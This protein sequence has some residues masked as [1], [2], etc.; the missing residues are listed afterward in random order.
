[1]VIVH[2]PKFIPNGNWN[3]KLSTKLRLELLNKD[4]NW[5]S[6]LNGWPRDGWSV[7]RVYTNKSLLL[8][9]G[10]ISYQEVS[11]QHTLINYLSLFLFATLP[12]QFTRE[13]QFALRD[14]INLTREYTVFQNQT[15]RSITLHINCISQ[16]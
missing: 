13:H 10:L 7:G 8:N 2:S 5:N 3:S 12:Q 14:L 15:L 11:A 6:K 16:Y 9:T 1:M 4:S